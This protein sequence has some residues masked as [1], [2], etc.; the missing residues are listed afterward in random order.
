MKRIAIGVVGIVAMWGLNA[1]VAAQDIYPSKPIRLV[2]AYAAGGGTDVA[3]RIF[4]ESLSR[5]LGTPV[6][7]E[8]KAGASGNIGGDFVAKAPADGYTL[9][10]GAMANLAINPYLYKDMA[11]A[12]ERDFTPITQVFDT[13]HVVVAGPLSGITSFKQM[14]SKGQSNPGK[15]TYASAGAGSST[16]VV[17][18]L[19]AQ[20]TGIRMVHIPYRGNAPALVDVMSGQVDLMFDQ[21]PNSAVFVAT[22]KVNA[23]AVTSAKRLSA[24]P[25]VPTVAELGYPQLEISSWTGLFGPS[26]LPAIVVSKLNS[27]SNK[28]LADP[29]TRARLEKAGAIPT[30]STP[31]LLAKLLQSDS[32]R[33]G[34]LVQRAGIKA[35]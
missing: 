29:D 9:L 22:K 6:I 7:V 8:N 27:G 25:D 35:D 26:K 33:F 28:A 20:A 4:A 17:A 30:P 21:V 11:Y 1:S 31:E 23:L 19:V 24:M 32:K 3:A 18:E 12:P 16:H 14:L 5:V 13:N 10:F 34:A 2:V 15:L